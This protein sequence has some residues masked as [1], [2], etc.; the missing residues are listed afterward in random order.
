MT[1]RR[2][3]SFASLTERRSRSFTSLRMTERSSSWLALIAAGFILAGCD[4]RGS[5]GVDTSLPV[6][7][8]PEPAPG[9]SSCPGTGLWARCS[10]LKRLEQTALRVHREQIKPVE[11]KPLSIKGFEMPIARGDIRVFIYADSDSRRRDEARLDKKEFILP[12][13]EPGFKRERTIVHSANLLVLMNV[14]N[15][16]SRERIANGLMA[17]PPQP[18][19]QP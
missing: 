8:A 4:S 9:D 18:P 11:E 10:V 7:A 6:V 15:G 19:K 2:S 16:L 17:G 13:Q 3:R 14:L 12:V 1:E 5:A